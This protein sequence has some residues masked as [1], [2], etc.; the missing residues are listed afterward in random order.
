MTEISHTLPNLA[1]G[2]SQQSTAERSP[3]AFEDLSNCYYNLVDG[4]TRRPGTEYLAKISFGGHPSAYNTDTVKLHAIDRSVDERYVLVQG[5]VGPAPGG[6]VSSGFPNLKI[7]DTEGTSVLIKTP[8]GTDIGAG[9]STDSAVNYLN[10]RTPQLLPLSPAESPFA[11]AQTNN[12]LPAVHDTAVDGPFGY[13]KAYTFEDDGG[14][15]A[16]YTLSCPDT[17]TADQN[18]VVSF[19]MREKDGLTAPSVFALRFTNP[20][21]SSNIA[22]VSFQKISGEWSVFGSLGVG[23]GAKV[24]TYPNGWLRFSVSINYELTAYLGTFSGIGTVV[25]EFSEASAGFNVFGFQVIDETGRT[26]ENL[27]PYE[28]TPLEDAIRFRTVGDTT[29]VLNTQQEVSMLADTVTAQD[30]MGTLWV[31]GYSERNTGAKLRI[32]IEN[33]G[34]GRT[35][36]FEYEVLTTGEVMD[37][38]DLNTTQSFW[39]NDVYVNAKAGS[40]NAYGA[41]T[42][43]YAYM[44]SKNNPICIAYA[45]YTVMQNDIAAIF[46][47][48]GTNGGDQAIGTGY[49][50]GVFPD[51]QPCNVELEDNLVF[52]T[53]TNGWVVTKFEVSQLNSTT[54]YTSESIIFKDKETFTVPTESSDSAE[55]T[56]QAFISETADFTGLPTNFKDSRKVKL[57]GSRSNTADDYWVEFSTYSGDAFGEGYWFESVAPSIQYRLDADTM[58]HTLTRQQDDADGSIT[59][60]PFKIYFELGT[61]TWSDREVGDTDSNKD[62]GFVGGNISEIAFHEGRMVF[63]SGQKMV[64]SRAQDIYDFWRSTTQSVPADD[65][66]DITIEHEKAVDLRWARSL[67]QRLLLGGR[68]TQFEVTSTDS[69]FSPTTV[70]SAVVLEQD[71]YLVDPQIVGFSVFAASPSGAYSQILEVFPSDERER[72]RTSDATLAVPRYLDSKLIDSAVSDSEKLLMFIGESGAGFIYKID[73]GNPRLGGWAKWTVGDALMAGE[74]IES[75]FFCVA[76]RGTEYF[77]EKFTL[78]VDFSDTF[79]D[80]HT[81]DITAVESAGNTVITLPFSTE[82]P[83]NLAVTVNGNNASVTAYTSSTVTI[84]GDQTAE[85]LVVG[86]TYETSAVL[87]RPHVRRGSSVTGGISSSLDG[88]TIIA[89]LVILAED[90]EA[91]TVS[92]DFNGTTYDRQYL[93]PPISQTLI[94]GP[95]Q[96]DTRIVHAI[97]GQAIETEVTIKTSLPYNLRIQG[98][99]WQLLQNIRRA[100]SPL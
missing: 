11:W 9:V 76:Q 66:I 37:D 50:T 6:G 42:Q 82:Q 31:R 21:D 24:E 81:S 1:G 39:L 35:E 51:G 96:T 36:E 78:P 14:G 46:G 8:T 68:N 12:A 98:L 86:F 29:F 58:P 10:H 4:L 27:P 32:T 2:V 41:G 34:L 16:T 3:N 33:T 80:A 97:G 67:D 62:P 56:I 26:V 64:T 75:D 83:E 13:G 63:L 55:T 72:Y 85:T 84:Q 49:D 61:P 20:A 25:V 23:E 88:D 19:F 77:L 38:V 99:E 22:T 92:V 15:L 69:V 48:W 57:I 28:R 47:A 87:S 54:Y 71:I 18:K 100:W 74:F 30:P 93:L 95:S 94:D 60:T 70:R 65:R 45:F 44:Y 17:G 7:Y 40:A 5:P 89:S 59:G 90:S 91:F 43:S 79:L 52:V 53:G 73:P